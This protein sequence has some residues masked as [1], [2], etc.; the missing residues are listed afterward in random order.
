MSVDDREIVVV[1]LRR[2]RGEQSRERFGAE[3]G[4]VAVDQRAHSL[5]HVDEGD[6]PLD[7]SVEQAGGV[8]PE[9]RPYLPLPLGRLHRETVK[10]ADNVRIAQAV[11]KRGLPVFDHGDVVGGAR[12]YRL[13][14]HLK[15]ERVLGRHGRE[16]GVQLQVLGENGLI[17]GRS[18]FEVKVAI[19]V[20]EKG[21]H[22]GNLSRSREY[23][24]P[25]FSATEM[26]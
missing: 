13:L 16:Q 12:Q 10:L 22:D 21:F 11:L 6:H 14:R 9:C 3:L 25:Y 1:E 23:V 20:H 18:V 5:Q 19:P 4:G 15:D 17:C 26:A 7:R 8:L 24:R 2:E